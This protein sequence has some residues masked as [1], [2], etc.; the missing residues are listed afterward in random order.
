MGNI[1]K[2]KKIFGDGKPTLLIFAAEW[3]PYC[4]RELADVQ[5]FYEEIREDY[6]KIHQRKLLQNKSGRR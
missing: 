2:S 5:K 3:C 6:E 4:Q 1:L